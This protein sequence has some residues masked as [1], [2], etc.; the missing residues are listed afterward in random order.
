MKHRVLAVGIATSAVAA[1][2]SATAW[3]AAPSAA[4]LPSPDDIVAGFVAQRDGVSTTQAKQTLQRKADRQRTYDALSREGVA[5]DGAYFDGERLVVLV[6][7]A[8]AARSVEAE[9]LL[10]RRGKGQS[11]LDALA[12]TALAAAK[13]S[14]DLVSL[15]PDLRAQSVVAEVEPDA[16]AALRSALRGVAGVTVEESAPLATQADVVPGRIMDL[17]PGTNCTLGFPGT[18]SSGNN[19]LLTAGHCVE[20]LPDILDANGTHIGKG[21]NSRFVSGAPSV[22]MGLMDIDAEDVGQPY[23]DTRGGLAGNVPVYG[24]SKNAVGSDICKAGNTTGWTCGQIEAYNVTVN[25]QGGTSVSGLARATVCTEGGDSGGAYIGTNNYAQGM[26]SGG[27][28]GVDC[29]FNAGY[30]AGSYSFYQP[31]VDAASYYGV[32]VST[33]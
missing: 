17:S 1:A 18:T 29:G 30:G 23:V 13:G 26:T 19:V 3:A 32:T 7:S 31:V 9:G 10:A 27:P 21:T 5:T 11:D 6:D 14:S 4:P 24:A 16:S 12:R 28:V 25:Y 15:T 22:D 2:A 20:G 33:S 8:A